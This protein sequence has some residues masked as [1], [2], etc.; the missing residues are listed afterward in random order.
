MLEILFFPSMYSTILL[1]VLQKLWAKDNMLL[2][3]IFSFLHNAFCPYKLHNFLCHT[4]LSST[5]AFSLDKSKIMSLRK[6]LSL[7]GKVETKLKLELS[8]NV[9]IPPNSSLSQNRLMSQEC[10]ISDKKGL[11][12]WKF[13]LIN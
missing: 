3:S 11:S 4:L 7:Y 2:I 12:S 6:E 9:I 1:L 10:K 13:Y 8:L 5:N